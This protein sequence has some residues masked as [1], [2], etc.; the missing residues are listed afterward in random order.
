MGTHFELEGNI[1]GTD[2]ESG[3][4]EKKSPQNLEGKSACLGLPLAAWNFSSEKSSLPFLAWANTLAKNTLHIKGNISSAKG[5]AFGITRHPPPGRDSQSVFFGLMCLSDWPITQT[6]G[7][8]SGTFKINMSYLV[9][10]FGLPII[11]YNRTL[12]TAYD[13]TYTVVILR[14]H[15]EHNK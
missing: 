7:L 1:V 9:F 6:C 2:W 13:M 15:W 4:N 14:T 10:L 3:E 12:G 8:T 5:Q 11:G